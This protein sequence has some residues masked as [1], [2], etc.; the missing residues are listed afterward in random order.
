MVFVTLE[1]NCANTLE[2]GSG[3]IRSQLS[4][5]GATVRGAFAAGGPADLG[6]SA[7]TPWSEPTRGS[8]R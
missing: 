4:N 6:G 3:R 2:S 5:A 7:P 8:A 1:T